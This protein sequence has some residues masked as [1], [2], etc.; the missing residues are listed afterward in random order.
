MNFFSFQIWRINHKHNVLYVS[1][2][3]VPGPTNSFC[4][5][6]DT[7]VHSNRR[8][9]CKNFPTYYPEEHVNDPLPEEEYHPWIWDFREPT[10][11]FEKE[12][13]A[14]GKKAK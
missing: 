10:L 3:A 5:I 1:G 12:K 13:V 2:V 8:K 9:E 4:Y 11:Q 14:A 7:L 6:F